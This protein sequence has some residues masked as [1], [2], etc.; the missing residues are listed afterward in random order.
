MHALATFKDITGNMHTFWWW[1]FGTCV[2]ITFKLW[3]CF[4]H[5]NYGNTGYL[6]RKFVVSAT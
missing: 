4:E 1:V 3:Y 2:V 5:E 6:K